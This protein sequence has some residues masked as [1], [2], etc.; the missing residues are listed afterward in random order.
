MQISHFNPKFLI[1]SLIICSFL[2][3]GLCAQTIGNGDFEDYSDCPDNLGQ[4][5][6]STGWEIAVSSSDYYNCDFLTSTFFPTSTGAS[7]GTGFM[8]M[9]SYGIPNG[10]AESI[11]TTLST[12][13]VQG[14]EYL[15]L[16]DV[17]MPTSGSYVSLCS[18][19]SFYGFLET[20]PLN[21]ISEHISTSPG[22]V[23]LD[24]TSM[25]TSTV[26]ETDSI[27]FVA[28]DNYT[29]LVITNGIS[30]SCAQYVFVDNIRREEIVS[31]E[32]QDVSLKL[33][34]NLLHAG[35]ALQFSQT[36][37]STP[38]LTWYDL[39]GKLIY[40]GT[41]MTTPNVL[42]LG[43]YVLHVEYIDMAGNLQDGRYKVYIR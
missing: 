16:I 28:Q 5:A 23:L 11:G 10:A 42:S 15:F 40:S 37:G 2:Q 25:V 9:A 43:F 30:A 19:I 29:Y 6:N 33:F 4:V 35:E 41:S 12:P 13:M 8:G 24:S 27:R 17:K 14:E 32:E 20:P 3:I 31:V 39:S 26:W 38:N 1:P 36:F 34:S 22:A 18:G 21:F 7:S